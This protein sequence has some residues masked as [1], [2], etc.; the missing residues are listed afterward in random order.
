MTKQDIF[1]KIEEEYAA[2][3][4]RNE[5]T[6]QQRRALLYREF[7]QLERWDEEIREIGIKT[8][9]SVL[10]SG[11]DSSAEIAAMEQRIAALTKNKKELLEKSGYPVSYLEPVYTCPD[12]KD[13]GRSG[14]ARCGCFSRRLQQ[15]IYENSGLNTD[16]MRDFSDFSLEVYE[17]AADPRR[18]L[19]P[20]ENMR[21]V[22][23]YAKA[24]SEGTGEYRH[25]LFHGPTGLGKTFLSDCVAREFAGRGKMVFYM[26]APALFDLLNNHYFA[27]GDTEQI[28]M[29]ITQMKECDLLI[30]D[31]LGTEFRNSFT[32]S[33]LFELINGRMVAGAPMLISTNLNMAELGQT[34]SE[35]ITSR[36]VGEF[37]IMEFFGRDIRMMKYL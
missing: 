14:T 30:I 1:R 26:S 27:K 28:E 3:R 31:D 36:L 13:T 5:E 29:Q 34:Y 16:R 24:F 11:E 32:D 8:A 6:T 4:A 7:P 33:R 35:R 15:L 2:A 20:R 10:G 23:A 25:L 12:C 21:S 17:D 18:G 22:L 9:M 19:S 37:G